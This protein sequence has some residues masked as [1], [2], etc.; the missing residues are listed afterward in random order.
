[1]QVGRL[2]MEWTAEALEPLELTLAEFAALALIK[3]MGPL[4]QAAIGERLGIRKAPMSRLATRLEQ[5]GL[6]ERQMDWWD[7]RKRRLSITGAGAEIVA[8]AADELGAVEHSFIER[9]GEEAIQTLAELLPPD[10]SPVELALRAAA[11]WG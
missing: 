1:M 9:V 6:A 7:G 5:A 11:G 10:L 2:A 4:T 3:R 8:E